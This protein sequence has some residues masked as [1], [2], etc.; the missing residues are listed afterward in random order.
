M[1]IAFDISPLQTGHK[2]RGVGFYVSHLK[3]ALEKYFPEEE[4]TFF[5]SRSEIKEA[6]VIHFPYFEPFFLSQPFPTKRNMVTTIHDLTPLRF[7]DH[8]PSGMKGKLM[9]ELQKN[10]AKQGGGIITDSNHSK[11]DIVDLL[12]VPESFVHVVYLAAGEEFKP[13][14]NTQEVKKKY[15]LPEKFALYVG[16]VTWNKNLPRIIRAA[17]KAGVPLILVGKSIT[18]TDFD[19]D[20]P[21]NKDLVEVQELLQV[22]KNTQALGFVSSEDL[23][24]LYNSATVF[25]MPS[26]Y[27]GFGLPILEAMQSGCPVITSREGSLPEVAGSAAY[28]VNAY[29]EKEI[30]KGIREIFENKKLQADL[31]EK[32]VKQSSKFSWKRTALETVQVYKNIHV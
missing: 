25:V 20:N 12:N 15:N 8:F 14:G 5:N 6:D 30:S 16:D 32:G 22:T 31:T 19:K 28:Y 2:I 3:N 21:W 17:E 13:V 7:P 11:K 10:L 4:Y 18:Q 27:E 24:S 23:V 29:D 9:W 26:L 1:K